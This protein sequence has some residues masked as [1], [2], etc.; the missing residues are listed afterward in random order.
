MMGTTSFTARLTGDDQTWMAVLIGSY[1]A[2]VWLSGFIE[3]SQLLRASFLGFWAGLGAS[4]ALLG[5][6]SGLGMPT[7][8]LAL[9]KD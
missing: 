7:V 9:C 3:R 8:A 4:Y 2:S 6:F 5:M 1:G